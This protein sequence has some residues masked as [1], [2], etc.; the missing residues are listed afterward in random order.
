VARIHM[1]GQRVR[2]PRVVLNPC[3]GESLR[4]TG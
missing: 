2:V 1:L 3:S 4:H